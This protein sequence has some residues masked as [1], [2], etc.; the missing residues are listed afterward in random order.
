MPLKHEH[1]QDGGLIFTTGDR[2]LEEKGVV[3][4]GMS[5]GNPYYKQPII[6]QYV[7]FLG[8][9]PRKIVVFVPQQP[10]VHTYRAMGSKDAVKRAKKH[11]DYLRAHCK[12]AIKKLSKLRELPGDFHF[13]DWPREVATH[14]VYQEK[15]EEITRLYRTNTLFRQDSVREVARVLGKTPRDEM[16]EKE[17]ADFY[18]DVY[19]DDSIREAVLYIIEE[20]A[21]ILASKA[22]YDADEVTFI[23]H[24]SWPMLEKLI[25]GEYDGKPRQ[26]YGFCIIR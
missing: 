13:V 1:H 26:G 25:N 4:F 12:R 6:E 17:S 5:P 14:V 15:L 19:N 23:Y 11:A 8:K 21:Y 24:R 22:L 3:L 2:V 18:P 16:S 20:F 9:E 7:E 10:S